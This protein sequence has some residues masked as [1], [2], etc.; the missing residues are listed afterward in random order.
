[1]Q[2]HGCNND[3]QRREKAKARA[4]E[5]ATGTTQLPSI[6]T[7]S[8]TK[9][10]KIPLKT[11]YTNRNKRFNHCKLRPSYQKRIIIGFWPCLGTNIVYRW[12]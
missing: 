12:L 6:I 8:K 11:H 5:P 4:G 10:T 2:W 1:M 9:H 7:V 3:R